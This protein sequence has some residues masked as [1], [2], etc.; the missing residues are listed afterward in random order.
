MPL[1]PET[2][3]IHTR[4]ALVRTIHDAGMLYGKRAVIM[5]VAAWLRIEDSMDF[6][7]A[8]RYALHVYSRKHE[9]AVGTDLLRA[10]QHR[11]DLWRTWTLWVD[12]P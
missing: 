8:Q 5:G 9:S 2:H 11:S 12:Y 7:Y 4:G 10:I 6:Q 1:S 3:H